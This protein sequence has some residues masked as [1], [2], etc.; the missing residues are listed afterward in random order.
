MVAN[1]QCYWD[2]DSGSVV[3]ENRHKT[4]SEKMNIPEVTFDVLNYSE[5]EGI[6]NKCIGMVISTLTEPE[7]A[8]IKQF[9]NENAVAEPLTPA[10]IEVH[11]T[12]PNAHPDIRQELSHVAER[13]DSV[14]YVGTME[15]KLT[16]FGAI[17][18]TMSSV[19]MDSNN[20]LG[21]NGVVIPRSETY[22]LEA[23]VYLSNIQGTIGDNA[24]VTVSLVKNA[25]NDVIKSAS[26]NL[27]NEKGVYTV[28]VAETN[29]QTNDFVRVRI[30]FSNMEGI[31]G[32]YLAPFRNY[33]IVS[34]VNT[35][36]EQMADLYQG[37]LGNMLLFKDY[38]LEVRPD[39]NNQ[40]S[41]IAG[42][43]NSNKIIK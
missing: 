20:N 23:R 38:E 11:N 26:F 25:S 8:A 31:T 40:P 32:A 37:T 10:D 30:E 15:M 29:L 43:W 17:T 1:I 7:I 6:K 21:A 27:K 3:Y 42:T 2:G 18:T 28:Y 4:F 22:R 16:S 5:D 34:N 13:A 33:L 39:D 41:V 9:A 24:T 19:L 12:D 36:G 35:V 14:C